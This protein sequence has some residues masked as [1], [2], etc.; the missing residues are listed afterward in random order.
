MDATRKAQA[1]IGI[2]IPENPM[3]AD[4]KQLQERAMQFTQHNLDVSFSA[5]S[6]LAKAKHFKEVLE[7][8]SRH[9]QI[10]MAAYSAQAQ[11]LGRLIAGATL[12]G[13]VKG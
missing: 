1:V 8:Q 5:A 12:N 2:L 3:T 6:E 7:I 11:E 13:R 9:A 10:Q 4:M